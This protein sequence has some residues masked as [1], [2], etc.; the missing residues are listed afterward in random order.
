MFEVMSG[1]FRPRKLFFILLCYNAIEVKCA[2][3][4]LIVKE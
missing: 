4:G 1:L 3:Q 2:E